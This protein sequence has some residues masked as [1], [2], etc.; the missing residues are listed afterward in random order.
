[1]TAPPT[2]VPQADLDAFTNAYIEAAY[3]TD[4]GDTGQPAATAELAPPARAAAA[5]SC[6]AFMLAAVAPLQEACSRQGYSLAQAGHDFWLTRNG[7]GAGFWD[8]DA[9]AGGGLG[10][11]L[12]DLARAQGEDDLY[13]G[14]DGLLWFSRT[15]AIQSPAAHAVDASSPGLPAPTRSPKNRP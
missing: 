10:H 8:R 12:S 11:R 4:T 13:E 9:L 6:R 14:D 3:F 7:H 15:P 5:E 1:M 2:S